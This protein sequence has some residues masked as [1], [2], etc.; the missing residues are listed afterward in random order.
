MPFVVCLC[1]VICFGCHLSFNL[2]YNSFTV[3]IFLKHKTLDCCVKYYF[4]IHIFYSL[5]PFFPDQFS[6]SNSFICSQIV[7]ELR[8]VWHSFSSCW[9]LEYMCLSVSSYVCV[10]ECAGWWTFQCVAQNWNRQENV[11]NNINL[12]L[13]SFSF[14]DSR[15]TK[16]IFIISSAY[17]ETI[18][19]TT[20]NCG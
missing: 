6:L 1:I 14:Y 19:F 11:I 20:F 13:I 18:Q 10:C 16:S 9:K 4:W 5:L 15:A 17:G 2:K 7:S 3:I 8:V 12:I